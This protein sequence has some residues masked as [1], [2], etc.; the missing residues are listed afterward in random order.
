MPG[1]TTEGELVLTNKSD[2]DRH[3]GFATGAHVACRRRIG[4]PP[5]GALAEDREVASTEVVTTVSSPQ[6][7]LQACSSSI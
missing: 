6:L 1:T 7:P 3:L 4:P 5:L 2:L